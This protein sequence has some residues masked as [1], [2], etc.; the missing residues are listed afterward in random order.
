[1]RGFVR[2]FTATPAA[3]RREALTG[4]PLA[5]MKASANGLAPRWAYVRRYFTIGGARR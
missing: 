5:G 3:L 4:R 2:A 1:M